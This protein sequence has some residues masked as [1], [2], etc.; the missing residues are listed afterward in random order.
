MMYLF[1]GVAV[2]MALFCF[3]I[4]IIQVFGVDPKKTKLAKKLKE[5]LEE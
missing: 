4:V 2:G 3:G 5:K 1:G